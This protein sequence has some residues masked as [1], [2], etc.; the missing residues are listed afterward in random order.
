MINPIQ[1]LLKKADGGKRN[2]IIEPVLKKDGGDL[3]DTGVYELYKDAFGEES[4]LFTEPL[5]IAEVNDDLPDKNNPDYLGRF[6]IDV[7]GN[8]KYEGD[9]LSAH[10]QQQ[11]LAYIMKVND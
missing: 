7:N 11:V 2:I 10:E 6:S 5:E 1:L 8:L 9:L 4:A 3:K